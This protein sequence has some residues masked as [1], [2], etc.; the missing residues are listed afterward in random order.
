MPVYCNKK[1]PVVT[2]LQCYKPRLVHPKKK[3]D[4]QIN[5]CHLID[6]QCFKLIKSINIHLR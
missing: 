1:S 6:F 5:V 4:K 3:G 2:L